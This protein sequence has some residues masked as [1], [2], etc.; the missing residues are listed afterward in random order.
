[1]KTTFVLIIVIAFLIE[2]LLDFLNMKNWNP[3]VP[4]EMKNVFTDGK[5]VKAR[6]YA[7]VNYSFGLLTAT[8]SLI[9]ML[10]MLGFGG[11]GMLDNWIRQYFHTAISQAL[12]FFAILGF[13]SDVLSMPFSLYKI[14]VIEERFGFNKMSLKTF[15]ADKIKGYLLA[16]IIGS[17]VLSTLVFLLEHFGNLFAVYALVFMSLIMIFGAM[18]YASWILPMFNKLTPLPAGELRSAIEEYSRKNQ[19]PLQDLFVMDGSKRSSKSNAFFSGL[20]KKKK[21]VLFDTL[22]QNHTTEELVAV[23]AHEIGHYRLKHTR[24]GVIRGILNMAIMLF[25]FNFIQGNQLLA[26]ALGA[27]QS[28]FHIDILAFSILYTPLSM[29]IG[30]EMN[31]FSRKNEFEAD[32]FARDTYSG[33][34]LITALKKLSADNLSNLTPHPAFVFVHYSHPPLIK[35]IA[36]IRANAKN[37]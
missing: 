5:Y 22:I 13:A 23:L 19:F 27:A 35:R 16:A 20:G 1:M 32:A 10:I 26:D 4:Q 17:I 15:F 8:F 3:A 18:F 33:E 21:I 34:P 14:F 24:S 7:K 11:F 12:V 25:V 2:R 37:G 28:S 36:A 9:L 29:L 31:M 30:I 6:N